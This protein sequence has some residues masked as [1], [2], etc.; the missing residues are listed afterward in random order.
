MSNQHEIDAYSVVESAFGR[1]LHL[2][3]VLSLANAATGALSA[4]TFGV[5]A[6]GRALA[7]ANSLDPKHAIKQVDR[8]LSN[9]GVD[10]DRLF[11]SWVPYVLGLRKEIV[12][13]LDWTESLSTNHSTP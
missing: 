12:V 7:V 4:A 6:I 3:R 5:A 11:S 2:K 10:P 9:P 13:A 1:D 8:L